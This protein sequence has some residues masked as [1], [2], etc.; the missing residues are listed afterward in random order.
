MQATDHDG[1][2]NNLTFSVVSDSPPLG[3]FEVDP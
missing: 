3:H 1:D 2:L